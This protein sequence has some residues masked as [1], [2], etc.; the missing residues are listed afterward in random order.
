MGA[1]FD[2]VLLVGGIHLQ[3]GRGEEDTGVALQLPVFVQHESVVIQFVGLLGSE[4]QF[5]LQLQDIDLD[6][7]VAVA[8]AVRQVRNLLQFRREAP[9]G[10][11][12][13]G[14]AFN[15][16]IELADDAVVRH[17][18]AVEV[19]VFLG[20]RLQRISQVK[21]VLL[22]LRIEHQGQLVALLHDGDHPVVLLAVPLGQAALGGED[23]LV[24]HLQFA[25]ERMQGLGEVLL[26]Q[27]GKERNGK[28]ES[29]Q[30]GE[31]PFLF[32]SFCIKNRYYSSTISKF[33]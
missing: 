5:L 22:L 13:A 4:T 8:E 6:A 1:V 21:S 20:D 33:K 27:H 9:Q 15:L 23:F 32:H 11:D 30:K 31:D 17:P 18:A 16:D 26:P 10:L 7:V 28:H 3:Q 25:A 12:Q 29:C 14:I 24:V 19:I 2:D